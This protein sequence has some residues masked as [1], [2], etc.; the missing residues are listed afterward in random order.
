MKAPKHLMP[1][2]RRW[3]ES[4]AASF[5]LEEHHERLL[6]LAAEAFDRGAAAREQLARE[7][8]TFRD[9]YGCPKP[10]PAAAIARDSSIIYAR[11]L[12]ELDLDTEAS[13]DTTRPPSLRSNRRR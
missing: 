8:L 1:A 5:V 6:I 10:H 4:V 11:L 9:R 13:P 7:G 12:R 2:T 3:V